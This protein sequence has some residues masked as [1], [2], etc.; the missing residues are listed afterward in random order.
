[1][2]F[3]SFLLLLSLS[4]CGYT[5][6]GRGDAW[7]GGDAQ[8]V[9]LELFDNR[10][11]QPYLEN[12]L[13]EALVMELSRSRLFELTETKERADLKLAGS[14]N[15]FSSKSLAYGLADQITD[16]RA[17]MQITAQLVRKEGGEVLWQSRMQR[18]EDYRAA[19]DKN[20]Q[21]D[22]ETLA[23]RQVSRRLAED[24]HAALLSNF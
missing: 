3:L 5:V 19:A 16:Y 12:Y 9:Y 21:L 24:L 10:T 1:M 22:A 13:T 4:A 11:A 2:R 23:A 7:V 18:N 20:L 8:L 17:T 14:V 15:A 6:P